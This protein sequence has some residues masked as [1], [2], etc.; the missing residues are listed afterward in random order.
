[1]M[2]D[3]GTVTKQLQPDDGAGAATARAATRPALRPCRGTLALVAV[4]VVIIDQLTKI[5]AVVALEG[6]PAVPILGD[7]FQL[8]L[9]RNPGAAFSM[10]GEGATWL[11][12]TIQIAFVI[13]AIWISGRLWTRWPAAA[14]GF[15][16]GGAGGNLI[17]RL[18]RDPSFYFGHVVDF[19]HVS[20]FAVFNMADVAINIGVFMLAAW[21]LFAKDHEFS[22][23]PPRGGA[24]VP[25]TGGGERDA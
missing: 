22:T 2:G 4:L 14:F 16:A 20:G 1:M 15:I 19:L 23:H 10:G 9:L 3:D 24:D 8:T 11:F 25:G 7:W 13:L 6:E 21:I 17:D 5:W 12:T 18:F